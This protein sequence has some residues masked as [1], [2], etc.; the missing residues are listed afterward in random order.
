MFLVRQPNVIRTRTNALARPSR[1]LTAHHLL[2]E[3][4]VE[5]GALLP[6]GVDLLLVKVKV[7]HD[8]PDRSIA[9]TTC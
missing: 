2:L 7:A 5:V 3:L 9:A 4:L 8:E 1:P 6:L